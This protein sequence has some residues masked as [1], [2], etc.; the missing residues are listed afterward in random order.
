MLSGGLIFFKSLFK[1]LERLC[2]L[3][4]QLLFILYFHRVEIG[5]EGL[6]N[7]IGGEG[8][9]GILTLL[10]GKK[11]LHYF[12]AEASTVEHVSK[13]KSVAKIIRI[14]QF[15]G[16]KLPLKF[17]KGHKQKYLPVIRQVFGVKQLGTLSSGSYQRNVCNALFGKF[18]SSFLCVD[19]FLLGKF[20]DVH[21]GCIDSLG[22]LKY[23][24]TIVVS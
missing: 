16:F 8:V 20:K 12:Y 14:D 18:D 23:A 3:F 7:C 6:L 4:V 10:I 21:T 1:R 17:R 11:A 19:L 5:S 15:A 9:I 24:G 22:L 13:N 2:L